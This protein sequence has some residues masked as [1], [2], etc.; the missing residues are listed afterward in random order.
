M[1]KLLLSAIAVADAIGVFLYDQTVCR[2]CHFTVN[3]AV[4]INNL[5]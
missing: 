1:G 3:I 5:L 4:N 2:P